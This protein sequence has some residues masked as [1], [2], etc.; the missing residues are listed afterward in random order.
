MRLES[1]ANR[2]TA[3]TLVVLVTAALSGSTGSA[4]PVPSQTS[5]GSLEQVDVQVVTAERELVKARLMDFGLTDQEATGRLDLLTDQEVHA[6][7]SDLDSVQAGSAGISRDTTKV[8]LLLI[9][10]F[11]IVRDYVPP[12]PS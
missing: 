4:A 9:F 12:L 5:S 1:K 10:L 11:L 6:L 7:A 2:V 8:L 3:L